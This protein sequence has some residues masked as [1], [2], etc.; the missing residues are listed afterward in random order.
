MDTGKRWRDEGKLR[1]MRLD[2]LAIIMGAMLFL[3]GV[4]L[5]IKEMMT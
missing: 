5:L 3:F 1:T 4:A 2:D